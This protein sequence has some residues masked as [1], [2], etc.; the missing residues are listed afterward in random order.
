MV[1]VY[2]KNNKESKRFP[3]GTSLLQMLSEFDFPR[4]YPIVSA[5]VNNVSQGLKF[6]VYQNKDIEFID[7][8]ESSGMRVYCRSLCFLLFKAARDVFPG[9]KLYMEHPISRGYFC[10]LRKE[11]GTEVTEGDLQLLEGRM[12]ELVEKGHALRM[13]KLQKRLDFLRD[14][15][16][17]TFCQEDIQSLFA[18][19]NPG[20][21]HVG[22]L[23]VRYGYAA[24]KEIAIRDYLNQYHAGSAY[25]RPEY[26]VQ[27]ILDAGG[28]PVLAH[29]VFGRGD[30]I[31]VGEDMDRRLRHLMAFGLKGV[32]AFYSGFTPML[33]AQMLAFAEK[34]ALYVTAGSDY[35]G[36]NK[37]VHLG[38][39]G[40]P[41]PTEYPSGL[42]RFLE[43]ADSRIVRS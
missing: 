8:R 42:L 5:K 33:I 12:R 21:P 31:I 27:T 1:Q 24:T 28:I 9:S 2:C 20:K 11:D 3:E 7:V 43:A 18:L 38:D 34:Y 30:E 15:F 4:P 32:E 23:M 39:T 25:V 6:K 14:R 29:P 17:F 37:L 26:A 41:D 16:G 22:N 36:S 13:G 35:H 10:H 40:L 19:D